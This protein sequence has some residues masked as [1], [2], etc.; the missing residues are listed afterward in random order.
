MKDIKTRYRMM[1]STTVLLLYGIIVF[2]IVVLGALCGLISFVL[3]TLTNTLF[4]LICDCVGRIIIK[5]N[6]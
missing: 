3:Q 2:P 6:E 4:D 5:E 1:I